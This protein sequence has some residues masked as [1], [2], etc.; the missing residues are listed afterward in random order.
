MAP[1]KHTPDKATFQA[2]IA[3]G[4]THQQMADRVFENTGY[5]VTRAAIT[6]ALMGYGLTSPKPRYK[7]EIP[8]RVKV[9]HAKTYPIRMLRFLGKRRAGVELPEGDARLLDTWLK[10]LARE[11]LIV[12]YD[13]EDDIGVHYIDARFRDH[14]DPSLPIRKKMIHLMPGQKPSR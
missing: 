3:E 11:R 6:V 7:E 12:A 4:L 5:R 9:E 14:D 10:R 13:A 2:W 1:K 8:W